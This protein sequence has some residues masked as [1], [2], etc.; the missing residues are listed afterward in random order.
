MF[1]LITIVEELRHNY[2]IV[3]ELRQGSELRRQSTDS[4]KEVKVKTVCFRYNF[5]ILTFV[6]A[7]FGSEERQS[8]SSLISPQ[9]SFSLS[10]S[11][12]LS[13]EMLSG[14]HV[15]ASTLSR[16]WCVV[17]S[18]PT[19]GSSFFFGKVTALGVLCCFALLFV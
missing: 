11:K 19:R 2:A 5:N 14:K 16:V 3:E 9:S 8:I 4:G 1:T 6:F 17:G 15:H 10:F 7:A 13:T 18:N 12:Q